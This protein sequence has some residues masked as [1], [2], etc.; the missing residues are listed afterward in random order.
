MGISTIQTSG[1]HQKS[2]RSSLELAREVLLI[3]AREVEAL[4]Q[5]LDDS[6]TRAV[7]LIL[8]C[9]GRVVVSGM[10]KSGHLTGHAA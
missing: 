8:Q 10:G 5:R 9:R 2:A 6:F 3:E 4:A 7:A 1:A